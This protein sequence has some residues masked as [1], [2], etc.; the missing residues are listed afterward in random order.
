MSGGSASLLLA[1]EIDR[2]N[3]DYAAALDERRFD[4][5]PEF[6]LADAKYTVQARE[7]FD[8]GLPLALIA[9]ESRGMMKDRV[10]GITQ[11]IFHGPYYTRHVV[12]PCRVIA[13][14]GTRIR[15][16]A[17][18]AVFRTK[19]GDVSEVY[20]VGRYIDEIERSEAGLRFASR[21]CIYDSEMVLNSLIYPV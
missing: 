20:N 14:E 18:Y 5:W 17:N 11:T 7:N 1:V 13:S 12:S 8:R 4:D 10:Y 9:L 16:E 21:L 3:A 6:F 19:P 2:L 15:A